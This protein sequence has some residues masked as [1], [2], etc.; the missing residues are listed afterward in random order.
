M[1]VGDVLP[2]PSLLASG[3]CQSTCHKTDKTQRT[4][5]KGGLV[6]WKAKAREWGSWGEAV[7]LM[8]AD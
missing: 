4:E 6:R 1:G 3:D 5:S 8:E 2:I 7:P